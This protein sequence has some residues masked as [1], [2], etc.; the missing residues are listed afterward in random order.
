MEA[1]SV[2][3]SPRKTCS[4][5]CVRDDEVTVSISC[6]SV[7]LGLCEEDAQCMHTKQLA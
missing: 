1:E 7:S 2:T 4:H 6:S 5:V 3:D